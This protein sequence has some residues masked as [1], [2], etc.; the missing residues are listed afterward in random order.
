MPPQLWNHSHN[1]LKAGYYYKAEDN[2][3]FLRKYLLPPQLWGVN[4]VGY[5][6]HTPAVCGGRQRLLLNIE[7]MGSLATGVACLCCQVHII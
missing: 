4:S 5:L 1:W 6:L 7:L 2:V 3:H